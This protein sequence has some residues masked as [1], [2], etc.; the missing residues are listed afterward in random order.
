MQDR[1]LLAALATAAAVAIATPSLSPPRTRRKTTSK[2]EVAI[3]AE[4]RLTHLGDQLVGSENAKVKALTTM[5][6]ANVQ[7]VNVQDLLKGNNVEAL[8]A[9]LTKNEADIDA[10][11]TTLGGN[12]TMSAQQ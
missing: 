2:G 6:A 8:N 12:A 1:T 10:L 9:A 3:E 5:N 4:L 11:R 7:L